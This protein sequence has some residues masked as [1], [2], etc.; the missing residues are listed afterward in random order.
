VRFGGAF[1][2]RGV[3]LPEVEMPNFLK[4]VEALVND[5]GQKLSGHAE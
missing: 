4:K 5:H 3:L 2:N 1:V